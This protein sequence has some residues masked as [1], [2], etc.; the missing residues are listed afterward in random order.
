VSSHEQV[1]VLQYTVFHGALRVV[2]FGCHR[3]KVAIPPF[4]FELI[5]V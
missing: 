1:Q 2:R 5:K 3:P 4:W